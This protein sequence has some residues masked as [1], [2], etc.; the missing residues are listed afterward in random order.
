[1]V[2]LR[3]AVRPATVAAKRT[4]ARGRWVSWVIMAGYALAA[5]GLTSRLWAA[6]TGRLPT[7]AGV[8]QPD[9][10]LSLWFIRY[11]AAAVSHGHLPALVTTKLNWPQGVN[12]MWNTSLLLP[13]VVLAPVTLLWGPVVTLNVLLTVGFAG[14]AAA[15]FWVLRRWGVSPGA[16]AIAG[17]LYGFSP[18]LRMT[19]EDHYHIQFAV[20]PPLIIDAAVRLV[21]GRGGR[22]GAVRSGI[23]LGLLVT[24]QLFIAEEILVDTVLAGV[25][26]VAVLLLSRPSALL[27]WRALA[28]SAAGLVI[29]VGVI[30]ILA[31][32]A[33]SIQFRGPLTETGSPWRLGHFGNN[34]IDFVSAPSGMLRHG[35]GFYGLLAST[36]QHASEYLAYLGWPLLVV[37]IV[38]AVACWRDIRART[39]AV[40]WAILAVLSMGGHRASFGGKTFPGVV[41]PWHWLEHLPLLSQ[42]VPDRLSVLADGA[43]AGLLAFAIDRVWGR[44]PKAQRGLGFRARLRQAV[45]GLGYVIAGLRHARAGL[46]HVFTWLWGR[47]PGR[48]RP[49]LPAWFGARLPRPAWLRRPAWLPGWMRLPSWPRRIWIGLASVPVLAVA[50]APVVPTAMRAAPVTGPPTGWQSVLDGLHLPAGAPIL[51]LP[52]NGPQLQRWQAVTSAPFSIVGGYCITRAPNGHAT[53]CGSREVA[54]K[55]QL[56]TA[57]L[58]R[59]VSLGHRPSGPKDS[60]IMSAIDTWRPAAV[61]MTAGNTA[62]QRY[63]ISVFGPPAVRSDGVLGWRLGGTSQGSV[64]AV[65]LGQPRTRSRAG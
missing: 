55:N 7:Y 49:R 30:L 1:M 60:T 28:T 40:C 15:M 51:T 63:L 21:I 27:R 14:S 58:L 23:W 52:V 4:F 25:L 10:D 39:A 36:N 17:A 19:G 46:R 32:H 48:L 11:S 53:E 2:A 13:G 64:R 29:A 35:P 47:V 24:A 18:A 6:P 34:P 20:L 65:Q 50:L 9:V 26:V 33:L 38:A 5:V 12:L 37:L 62:L 57:R 3:V 41:M 61:V 22:L 54:T 42:V 8:L 45:A 56:T 43:A 16:A 31:G 59:L 44:V